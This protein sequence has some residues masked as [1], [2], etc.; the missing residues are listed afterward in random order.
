MDKKNCFK[1]TVFKIFFTNYSFLIVT[2]RGA[3]KST[4]FR[5]SNKEA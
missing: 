5:K 3:K 1:R 2:G 4:R